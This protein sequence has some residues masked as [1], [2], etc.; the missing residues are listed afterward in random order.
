VVP[1][2]MPCFIM[3][4]HRAS[5]TAHRLHEPSWPSRSLWVMIDELAT[6]RADPPRQNA[7]W[8]CARGLLFSQSRGFR[9]SHVTDDGTEGQQSSMWPALT[10]VFR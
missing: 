8:S 5:A 3:R 2:T 1:W 4:Q 10:P 7:R 9:F 6:R